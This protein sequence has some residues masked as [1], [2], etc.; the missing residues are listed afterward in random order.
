MGSPKMLCAG[1]GGM[2]AMLELLHHFLEMPKWEDSAMERAKQMFLSVY[3]S[4]SKNL[5]RATSHRVLSA[6]FGAE[7]V[8]KN[9]DC[10]KC[11]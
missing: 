3:H 9:L 10:F 5:E 1:N 2:Q 7:C 8:S 6:M 4:L 11:W